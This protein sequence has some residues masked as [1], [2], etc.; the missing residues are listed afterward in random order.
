[1]LNNNKP[2]SEL[3]R[4]AFEHDFEYLTAESV[5]DL[6]K[7][8][9]N[10]ITSLG[11]HNPIS[12][13]VEEAFTVKNLLG[14]N[15][16]FLSNASDAEKELYTELVKIRRNQWYGTPYD[17]TNTDKVLSRFTPKFLTE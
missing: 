1:M 16:S 9:S 13:V 14:M 3:D 15:E 4:V 7:A 11:T 2:T 17:L 12:Q 6:L 10:M 8:D 5:D